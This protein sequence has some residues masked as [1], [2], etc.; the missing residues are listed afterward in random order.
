MDSLL[1][2]LVNAWMKGS[3]AAVDHLRPILTSAL[4]RHVGRRGLV[5]FFFCQGLSAKYVP[6]TVA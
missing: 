3:R 1:R 2:F 5:V 4:K 6:K